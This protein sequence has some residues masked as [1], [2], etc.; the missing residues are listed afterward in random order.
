MAMAKRTKEVIDSMIE[1]KGMTKT[2]NDWDNLLDSRITFETFKKY[3]LNEV[4]EYEEVTLDEVVRLLNE[5]AGEDC[6]NCNW[7]YI[8]KDNKPFKVVTKYIWNK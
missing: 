1:Y 8:V 4:V 7:Y 5:C 2:A 6:Y 3:A